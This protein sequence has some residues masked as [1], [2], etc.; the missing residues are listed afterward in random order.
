MITRSKR[1][2]VLAAFAVVLSSAPFAVADVDVLLKT[3][4]IAPDG[5]VLSSFVSPQAAGPTDVAFLGATSAIVTKVG[6]TFATVVATGDPLPAPLTGTFNAVFDPALNDAGNVAF[7]ASLNSNDASSGLFFCCDGGAIV[8]IRLAGGATGNTTSVRNPPDINAAGDVVYEIGVD[9]IVVWQHATQTNVPVASDGTAA[10]GGGVFNRFGDRPVL[11]DLGRVAF[12]AE[13]SGGPEGIFS[14]EPPYVAI[15]ACALEGAAS[16]IAGGTYRPF[17]TSA[18]VSINALGYVAFTSGIAIPG[19]DTSG[20]FMCDPSIPATVTVAKEGDLVGTAAL[21]AFDDE[22]VGIDD[23]LRVAF[24]GVASGRKLVRADGG[25]LTSLTSLTTPGEFAPRLT[26]SGRVVWRQ[27]GRIEAFDG[28]KTTVVSSADVTPIG[29]GTLPREPSINEAGDVAFRGSQFVLYRYDHGT[30]TRVAGPGDPSPGS[31]TLGTIGALA[32]HGSSLA[33]ATSDAGGG[34]IAFQKS[35][36]AIVP[37]VRAGDPAPGGDAFNVDGIL[38]DVRGP[39]VLFQSTTTL[40]ADALFRIHTGTHHIDRLA[41]IGDPAPGG[42]A[43]QQFLGLEAAGNDA[44]FAAYVDLLVRGL[45]L[46]GAHGPVEIVREDAALP[47]TG[48]GTLRDLGSF[49]VHGKRVAFT[50]S[51]DGG[52]V[53][54][55]VFLWERGVL[56]RLASS[57]DAVA[58]GAGLLQD[59]AGQGIDLG[60]VSSL[61]FGSSPTLVAGLSGGSASQGLFFARAPGSVVPVVLSGDP[62]SIG[63]VVTGLDV[64]RTTRVG[65]SVV[66]DVTLSGAGTSGALVRARR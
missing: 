25:V 23:G 14:S 36:G 41:T 65:T 31:G 9:Q 63:G 40:G 20:V 55:G 11:N 3:G 8:P 16:P 10:P 57:G 39:R 15:D 66:L 21:T 7:R 28:V 29:V 18:A 37:A 43:F 35:G 53:A 26:G 22:Y 32:Y 61:S 33:F 60:V 58:G 13:V 24:E 17:A 6:G 2:S 30:T 1:G 27:S 19:P 48:G 45:Y 44:V 46:T 56:R 64:D 4:D 47:D 34:L 52:T 49:A 12:E 42:G 62:T 38:L 50:A 51:V 59:V 5:R 54:D